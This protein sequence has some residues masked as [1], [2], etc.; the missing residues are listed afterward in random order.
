MGV[1]TGWGGGAR[2]TGIVGRRAAL[3]L[4]AWSPLVTAGEGLALGLLD[5][6]AAEQ[7]GALAKAREFLGGVLTNDA[8][9]ELR[10]GF[11]LDAGREQAGG[12]GGGGGVGCC[13]L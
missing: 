7:G 10:R 3:R 6:V 1:S 11:D 12:A 9:G 2:L 8:R 5:A 4:L 13:L